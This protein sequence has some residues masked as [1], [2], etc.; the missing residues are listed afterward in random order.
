MLD[1]LNNTDQYKIDISKQRGKVASRLG[2][3]KKYLKTQL[4]FLLILIVFTAVYYFTSAREIVDINLQVFAII[5]A[6]TV[7]VIAF[8][9]L[10][11]KWY[12]NSS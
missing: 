7:V 3:M 10:L 6:V 11:R 4:F 1:K 5:Y 8:T 12:E 9:F 2:R